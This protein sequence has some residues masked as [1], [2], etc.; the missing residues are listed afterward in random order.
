MVVACRWAA[1][2]LRSQPWQV[3]YTAAES[4]VE[5]SDWLVAEPLL[6]QVIEQ[7]PSHAAAHHLL[8]KVWREQERLEAALE[9]QQ[10]SCAFDP[11]LGWNWFAAGELLLELERWAEAIT[12][13]EQAQAA[14][15]AEGWIRE[16]LAAARFLACCDGEDLAAGVGPHTYRHWIAHHEPR[17]PP[18]T[19]GLNAPFWCLEPLAGGQ[20]RW[21]ALHSSAGLQPAAVPLG[22]S[23]WPVDGWLVLLGEGSE[24]R[25]GALQAVECWLAALPLQQQGLHG[26]QPDLLYADEDRRDGQGRRCDPWFKPGW[27]EES[28]WSSPWLGALSLWR[29]SWLRHA[30]LPLPPADAQGRW[31]WQLAALEQQPRISHVPLVLVHAGPALQ[32][33]PEALRQSLQR[34]GEAIAAVRPHSQLPG[35]LTLQWQLPAR[36]SCT[37]II[38]TRDRADL[39]QQCLASLWHT[40]ADARAA[41]LDLEILVVDNGSREAATEALLQRWQPRIE[42]R[43]CDAAFNWSQLNNQA[44]AQA[45]SDL[46]LLLNNDIEATRPGWLEAMAAQA[47]RPAVGCVGAVLLYPDGTIQH[48]GVVVGMHSGADHAYRDLE[49]GHGVHRGRSR[50]L[51]GWGAVT[52]ACLMLRRELLVR[53]GGFDEGLPV[54]FNDVD[55]CLRL[56]QLGYRHAIPPEAVLLHH[57]SQSRDAEGSSTAHQALLRVQGRWAGRLAHVAPWWPAQCEASCADGRPLGFKALPL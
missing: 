24:L 37:V 46:L 38:P 39:L 5:H 17:L 21:R 53:V 47:L 36:W 56:G 26:Q 14:L 18:A 52:G 22:P 27:V 50:L 40:T 32:P 42:V 13:F 35:C 1:L 25:P 28:F 34:Q 48:G 54:E 44:A 55:L 19:E 51:S 49:P 33:D 41:G 23:P 2:N 11:G 16:Q 45:S 31:R 4:A 43:R 29:L 10:R 12:A 20:Q 6:E 57:E 30:G 8:G 7:V 3:L 15:P 9:A